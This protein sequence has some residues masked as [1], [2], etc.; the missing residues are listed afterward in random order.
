MNSNAMPAAYAPTLLIA[1]VLKPYEINSILAVYGPQLYAL[2]D[3][4]DA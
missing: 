2:N 1:Y 4:A 3:T